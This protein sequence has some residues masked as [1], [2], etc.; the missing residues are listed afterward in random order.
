VHPL[1]ACLGAQLLPVLHLVCGWL[2]HLKPPVLGTLT[3]HIIVL[4]AAKV[5]AC[6]ALA[7]APSEDT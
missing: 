7:G 3:R 5:K 1:R 6:A 4:P 2:V